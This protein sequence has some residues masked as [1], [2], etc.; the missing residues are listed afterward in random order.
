MTGRRVPQGAHGLFR[1]MVTGR[2]GEGVAA[3]G[4]CESRGNV[5][6]A[7][8]SA[9][10]NAIALPNLDRPRLLSAAHKHAQAA[11][12]QRFR[13]SMMVLGAGPT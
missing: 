3:E 8:A 9:N 10:P 4:G 11:N 13:C 6:A 5:C 1:G 2:R 7:A 12:P